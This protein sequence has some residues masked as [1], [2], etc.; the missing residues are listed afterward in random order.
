MSGNASATTTANGAPTR[1]Q[2]ES[3]LR[4]LRHGLDTIDWLLHVSRI[5]EPGRLTPGNSVKRDVVELCR[6]LLGDEWRTA[7]GIPPA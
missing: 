6:A 7:R 1:E 2:L 5:L 4:K 3:E